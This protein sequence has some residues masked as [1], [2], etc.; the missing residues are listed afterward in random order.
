[1]VPDRFKNAERGLDTLK[2]ELLRFRK[3]T[4]GELLQDGRR[5]LL[6]A[7]REVVVM[8]VACFPGPAAA[9]LLPIGTHD[10]SVD[11]SVHRC[12]IA[13]GGLAGPRRPTE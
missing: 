9:H 6:E 3:R 11:A 1:V 7:E 4:F 2:R 10:V 5:S 8:A 13:P 12:S